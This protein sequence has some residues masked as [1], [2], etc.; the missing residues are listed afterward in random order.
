MHASQWALGTAT[1]A[2]RERS[3]AL[4]KDTPLQCRQCPFAT[5]RVRGSV[6]STSTTQTCRCD[7]DAADCGTWGS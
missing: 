6:S 5:A 4:A 7:V 3:T 2:L 1:C